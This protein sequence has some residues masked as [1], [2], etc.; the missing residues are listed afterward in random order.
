METP[1]D[2]LSKGLEMGVY[3]HKAPLWGNM[4]GCSFN[5]DPEGYA[6]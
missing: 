6:K 5:G 1:K 3:F 2:M 4:E